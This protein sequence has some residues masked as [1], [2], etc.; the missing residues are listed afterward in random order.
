[1]HNALSAAPPSLSGPWLSKPCS[2]PQMRERSSS[3]YRPLLHAR[4]F[5]F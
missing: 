3:L 4:S 5:W 2:D 1:M